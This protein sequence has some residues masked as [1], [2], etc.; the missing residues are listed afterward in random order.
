MSR[1]P[2]VTDPPR[3]RWLRATGAALAAVA[4]VVALG[5]VLAPTTAGSQEADLVERGQRIYG[6]QCATCHATRGRGMPSRGVPPLRGVG[7]AS[8]DFYIRTGRMPLESIDQPTVHGPQLLSDEARRA[9]I[10]YITSLPGEGPPIPRIDG[11]QEADLSRG[12]DLFNSN[13]AACHGPTGEGIAVGAEDIAPALDRATPLEIAEAV[14]VGP[15]VMPVFGPEVYTQADVEAV[16]RWIMDLRERRF[17]GGA[18]VGRSGPVSEGLVA[19]VLGMGS[20][21]VIMYLLGEKAG[22]TE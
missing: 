16:V 6:A 10:A 13:C 3:S 7:A 19:W 5:L 17:R 22:E 11:W 21:G 15:G 2:G 8:V 4:L 20:L 1:R 12:M 18:Q 14:R 9:L